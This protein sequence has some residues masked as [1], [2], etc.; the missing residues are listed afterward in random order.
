MGV[1]LVAVGPTQ[2][3]VVAAFFFQAED[4]MRDLV[5]SR[6][7]GGVYK[8]KQYLFWSS[9]VRKIREGEK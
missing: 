7:L 1:E 4:G 3:A 5:R 8:R 2:R 9:W 6:G